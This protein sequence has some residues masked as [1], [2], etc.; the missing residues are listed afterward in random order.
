MKWGLVSISR[1]DDA[2]WQF[3]AVSEIVSI[4]GPRDGA[5]V[6]VELKNGKLLSGTRNVSD[7]LADICGS[8]VWPG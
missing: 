1:K 8:Y 4:E 5:S 2:R 6:T 3:V 7:I